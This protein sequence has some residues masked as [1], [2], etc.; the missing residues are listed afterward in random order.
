LI[1]VDSFY[2]FSVLILLVGAAAGYSAGFTRI[3]FFSLQLIAAGSAAFFLYPIITDVLNPQFPSLTEWFIPVSFSG[4][5]LIVYIVFQFLISLSFKRIAKVHKNVFNR[6]AGAI[7]G[8]AAACIAALGVIHFNNVVIIPQAV[9]WGIDKSGVNEWFDPAA[10]FVNS[11]LVPVFQQPATQ[12]LAS[13]NADSVSH[14]AVMLPYTTNDFELRSDLEIQMLQLIN[15][16]RKKYGLRL[17]V[18][19]EALNKVAR[20]HSADMFKRGYFSHN[21]PEGIDPFQRLRKA[22]IKYLF[23]GENLALAPT[24]L[25][26]HSE[27]MKSPGHR[28]NILN[29]SY[30]RVGIGILQ[31]GAHGLMLTQEFRD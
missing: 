27:L 7:A 29:P 14:D 16:E 24:L 31:A 8:M 12:V 25:K 1:A 4:V 11:D 20:A 13:E 28:A 15:A 26:A 6:I 9:E 19:D 21:T 2:F 22:S 17:L 30:G 3:M 23:A 18:N 10:A 5:F